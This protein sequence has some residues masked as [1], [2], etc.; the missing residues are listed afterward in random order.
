M[1]LPV[2][3]RKILS[4]VVFF[5]VVLV[6]PSVLFAATVEVPKESPFVTSGR[7]GMVVT[8]NRQ[9]S[10]AGVAMLRQG[11]NA[12]DAAIAASFVVSVT[13]PQST[14][15]G[16]GGFLLLYR[17]A[18]KETVAVDFRERAPLK[19][20]AHM[21]VRDGNA[22]P[23]LSRN[24]ALAV[25][26]PGLVAGLIDVQKRYGTLPLSTV[27]APAIRLADDGFPV[28]AQL[29]Q[30]LTYRAQLLR[31]SPATRAIYFREDRP[32]RAG[33]LLVQKDLAKTLRAV[34]AA[35]KEAFY[36]GKVAEA[37]IQEVQRRGGLITQAD[38]DRYRVI[39]RMPVIG[40]YRDT[41]IHTMPPPSS[42]A[43]LVQMLRVLSGFSLQQFG[44]HSPKAVHLQTETLRLAFRDRARYLGDPDFVEIPLKEIL[45]PE[46]ANRLRA[47][48]NLVKAT[49]SEGIPTVPVGKIES[50]NT[51]HLSVLDKDG[52]AVATTQTVNLF[53][54]S[55]VMVP[56]TGVL[57]NNEMDD[58][59]AQPGNPNAF[60]LVGKGD[61]NAIEPY[62]T[63][64]SSMSPT[65]VTR[66]GK[67]VLIAGSPGG[68]RIISATLQV[69]L[70]V[71]EYDLSLPQAVFAPRIHH[72]WFPD[73]LQVEAKSGHEPEGLLEA[74]RQMGHK[75]SLGQWFGDVQ[76]VHV[77]TNSGLKIGVS[78]P[79]GE[80][81]PRGF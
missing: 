19:A 35:G 14:G 42:G 7:Q 33:E 44:F 21:F 58:F 28:Y 40:A 74:L 57:L 25:A 55:G 16:G 73:E 79:R 17:A 24:G 15:I 2:G 77:D 60:G 62:K 80:G 20:T 29:E 23:A 38:L 4:P 54:G 10:E 75:V 47:R 37:L 6:L 78:D 63:P 70:N 43:L 13:R 81:R 34:A 66:D 39:D 31:E 22:V 69:L 46:Y 18:D 41:R 52:N 49:P 1:T 30:A 32:L 72:Q 51:T 67:V 11:G 45:S 9:A 48:I 65:I 61:A 64:L 27:M 36:R 68:S 59:S 12:V 76:A 3:T 56:G 50:T 53:F 71:L 8:A 26:V 5:T